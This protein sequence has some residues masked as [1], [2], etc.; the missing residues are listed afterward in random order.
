[1]STG[2]PLDTAAAVVAFDVSE[3]FVAA[4]RRQRPTWEVF[5]GNVLAIA[6]PDRSC[7]VAAIYSSL[8][9]I[10]AEAERVLAELA[11]VARE[12]IVILEGVL[13]ER[14]LLR[15]ALRVW[16]RAFDGGVRYYTRRELLAAA[17]RLGLTVERV[18]AHGP[19]GHMLLVVLA[20][21]VTAEGL[22]R[23]R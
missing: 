13:P 11:R 12:R 18:S 2:P 9:H 15:A 5:Q 21:P 1:V 3:E 22:G 8:H 20:V 7:D 23:G 19:I 17:Q 10:P 14:G 4:C 6:R 16:Y